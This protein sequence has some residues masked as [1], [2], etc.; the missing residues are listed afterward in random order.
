MSE[1][2]AGIKAGRYHQGTLRWVHRQ[3]Y[4]RCC[5]WAHAAVRASSVVRR[6]FCLGLDDTCCIRN[7]MLRHAGACCN[8]QEP[9]G[10]GKGMC[11]A[12]GACVS[13]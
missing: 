10:M 6:C 12:C 5:S 8:M 2:T 11:A 9:T 13:T 1:I 7:S 4:I 3:C